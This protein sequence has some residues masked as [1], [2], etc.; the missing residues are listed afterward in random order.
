MSND[1]NMAIDTAERAMDVRPEHSLNQARLSAFLAEHL[2]AGDGRGQLS[3]AQFDAGQSNPTYLVTFA[4]HRYVLRK[5]PPGKLLPSAHAV[6]REFRI[7]QAL[8]RTNVPVPTLRVLCDDDSVIGTMFYLMDFIEGRVFKDPALPALPAPDRHR[9]FETATHTLARLHQ[10]DWRDVGLE[11]YG[12][13]SDYIARQIG[14]WS[15]QYEAS[16]TENI[17]AMDQLTLWLRDNM[18]ADVNAPQNITIAH[19]DFRIDNMIYGPDSLDPIAVLDWELSTIGHP[20]SD[21]AYCAM[22]Y[23]IPAG[24]QPSPGLAGL[25]LTENGL[26]SLSEFVAMYADA[27]GRSDV[28]AINYYMAFSKFRMA[29]ILQGVYKRSLDGNASSRIAG[30]VGEFVKTFAKAGLMFSDGTLRVD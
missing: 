22:M 18:P 14:R 19:G 9:V 23:F 4:G 6:D 3:L 1:A 15:D 5:K 11:D 27:A 28:S 8:A 24:A 20:L 2:P 7:M 21:F 17:P 10:V 29:A 30:Q 25:D 26:P 12:K 16:R 13:P